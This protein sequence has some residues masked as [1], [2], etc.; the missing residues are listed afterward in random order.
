MSSAKGVPCKSIEN[1]GVQILINSKT[2]GLFDCAIINTI[3]LYFE[4]NVVTFLKTA[5]R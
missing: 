3:I 5:I 4:N 2:K 1:K